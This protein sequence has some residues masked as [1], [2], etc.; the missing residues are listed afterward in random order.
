MHQ[1]LG[2]DSNDTLNDIGTGAG[3]NYQLAI[4]SQSSVVIRD[5]RARAQTLGDAL[6]PRL[7]VRD[8][9][10]LFI[11]LFVGDTIEKVPDQVQ[12]GTSL[13][14]GW[15]DIPG[16]LWRMRSLDHALVGGRIV[17]PESN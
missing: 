12:P 8:L 6:W 5:R 14:V 11:N 9:W 16:R 2:A 1:Q 13:V 10:Q 4:L 15:N 7:H 3:S 17:P